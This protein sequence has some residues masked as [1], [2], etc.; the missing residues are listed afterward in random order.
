MDAERTPELSIEGD[1]MIKKLLFC[2]LIGT[3]VA[4]AD[5]PDRLTRIVSPFSPGGGLDIVAR[6]LAQPLSEIY[7][8]PVVVENRTG[9]NGQVANEFVARSAPDG[10]TL[11]IDTLGFT[12][13][14][15]MTKN[16]RYEPSAMVPVAQL[17]SVPFI[18]VVNSKVPVKNVAELI[19]MA[20]RSPSKLNFAQGGLTNRILGEQF[21]LR[22]GTEFTFVPYRGS[23]PATLAV[24]TGESDLTITDLTTV[25]AHLASGKVRVLAVTG[26]KRNALI[27]DVPTMAEAGMAD[28][29]SV[30]YGI[31]APPDTPPAVVKR[32][33]AEFNKIV[34][35]PAM[36]ARLNAIGNE[37]VTTTPEV[38]A[39]LVRSHMTA[40]KDVVSRSNIPAD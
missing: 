37:P 16:L 23:N 7:A 27:P 36:T 10:Y 17:L 20:K 6:L 4:W 25:A 38:F 35:A 24:L 33:N 8:Q 40:V 26:T 3:P 5:Y 12:V 2:L 14:P 9:A 15:A 11:L 30:W 19:D 32:L 18:L 13:H 22:T 34:M 29:L 28:G 1:K 39:A 31:F 21:R